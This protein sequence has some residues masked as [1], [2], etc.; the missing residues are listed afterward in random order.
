MKYDHFEKIVSHIKHDIPCPKCK[1]MVSGDSV[2]V[3]SSKQNEAEF[4][5]RCSFCGSS[6][7][8]LA[9]VSGEM[10]VGAFPI[11]QK[12]FFSPDLAQKISESVRTFQG[13]DVN[14]L[15]KK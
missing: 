4:R 11:Q 5:V 7:R 2:E 6:I 1:N 10:P 14:E 8:V 9:Q 12:E 13:Q 3:I 15:F